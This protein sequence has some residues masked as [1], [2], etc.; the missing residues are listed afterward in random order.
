MTL[1]PFRGSFCALATPFR[2]DADATIDNIAFSRLVDWQIDQGTRGLIVAGSTG[3][4]AALDNAE[5]VALAALASARVAKRVPLGAGTGQPSTRRTIAMNRLAAD[6]GVDF[7]LVV[8]PPYVRPTQEGLYRHYCEV[9]DNGDIPLMLYNVPARTGCDLLPETVARLANHERII[10]IKEARPEVERMHQ[11]LALQHDGFTI[12]S[13]DDGSCATAVAAG[14]AGVIS[15]SANVAPGAMDRLITAAAR[16]MH[17]W[18]ALDAELQPLHQLMGLE[19]NPTPA[20]WC[21][22]RLGFGSDGM[23]LPLLALS[24]AYHSQALAVLDSLE[25]GPPP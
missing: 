16:Q 19:P 4:A 7:A 12:F 23:R 5:F 8:T 18:Q 21:L 14:A 24:T 2:D 9:A 25:S 15:V 22:S 1:Q 17:G 6:A 20:K 13:G 3:E 11:L 10:G